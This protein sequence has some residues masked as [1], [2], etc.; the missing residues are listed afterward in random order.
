MS[1]SEI[2]LSVQI[3]FVALLENFEASLG[4]G[5]VI[6]PLRVLHHHAKIQSLLGASYRPSMYYVPGFLNMHDQTAVAEPAT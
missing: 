3:L 1:H 5:K 2:H 4:S 6:V